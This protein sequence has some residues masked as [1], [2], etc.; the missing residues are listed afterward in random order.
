MDRLEP[1]SPSLPFSAKALRTRPQPISYLIAK[2][3]ANPRLIS[4]AAGLVDEQ[5]LPVVECRRIAQRLLEDPQ[6]GRVA[7]QYETTLGLEPLRHRL[8]QHLEELEGRP[9]SSM[10]LTADDIIL[11]TGSQ[12]A[13]YLIADCLIDPGDIVITA[14]PDY[15]VY[16]GALQS[17]GARLMAVPMDDDGMDTNALADLLGALDRQGQ[18]PRVKFIY[19]TSYYQ[20][21]T[22]LTL[23]RHRRAHM[24]QIARQFSRG[25]RI[26]IVEDGAYRELRYDGQPLP[27]IKSHDPDNRYTVL[28][29]TFSKPFSP[30]LKVG[31]TAVPPDLM[32][33]L[34][35]Q[36]ANHDF[37][38]PSLCQH[39]ALEAL[40]D[41][42]YHAHVA[43]LRQEYRRKR[44]A[45]LDALHRHMPR[46]PGLHWTEPQGGLYVWL[47][48]PH[49]SDASADSFI[50]RNCLDRGVLYVPGEY[51]F[52]PPD[53][54]RNHMR[55]CF[56]KVANEQILP[57]IQRLASVIAGQLAARTPAA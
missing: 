24:V 23:G 21:P 45:L 47:T 50:F 3:V 22:G 40:N 16:A 33:A 43:L 30:G 53:I 28:T 46:L 20:N 37:G 27:S 4:F 2:A 29:Q 19:C 48:L 56:G 35:H 11:T 7:L 18:L 8:L 54:P 41:G 10:S 36:K 49:G 13:L 38:S 42:S 31:Y 1:T 52:Q 55:L 32:Q 14:N 51:C 39:M 25:H 57:G 6:R 9:A 34:L 17:L 15:F 44:D 5:T 12:Q 26:L